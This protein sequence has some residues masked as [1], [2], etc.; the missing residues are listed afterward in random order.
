MPPIKPIT[1]TTLINSVHINPVMLALRLVLM[2]FS[3]AT[4]FENEY[5]ARHRTFDK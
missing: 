2:H 1:I 3:Q 4:G 5:G